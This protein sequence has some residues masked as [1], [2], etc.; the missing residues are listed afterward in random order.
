MKSLLQ[1]IDRIS[2]SQLVV[3]HK[4]M[5]S[6]DARERDFAWFV[7]ELVTREPTEKGEATN[8]RP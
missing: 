6:D 2:S 7:Y 5:N 8:A 1:S 4:L 3:L